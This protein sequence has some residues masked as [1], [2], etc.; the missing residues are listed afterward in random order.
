MAF[1][2]GFILSQEVGVGGLGFFDIVG[3]KAGIWASSS[4]LKEFTHG[5]PSRISGELEMIRISQTFLLLFNFLNIFQVRFLYLS[6]FT[7]FHRGI[8]SVVLFCRYGDRV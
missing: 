5:R 4:F 2:E 6:Y 8:L 7:A 1:G 3:Y